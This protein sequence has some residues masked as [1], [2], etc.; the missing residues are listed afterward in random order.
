[1]AMRLFQLCRRTTSSS[2]LHHS[3]LGRPYRGT[4][5]ASR[6]PLSDTALYQVSIPRQTAYSAARP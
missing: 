1:M 6:H 4:H 3:A 2:A 5:P